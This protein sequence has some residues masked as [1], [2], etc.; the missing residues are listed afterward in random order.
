MEIRGEYKLERGISMER[1]YG[2]FFLILY[3]AL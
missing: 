3:R 2:R 1:E